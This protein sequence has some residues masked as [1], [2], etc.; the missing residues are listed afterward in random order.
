MKVLIPIFSVILFF[1]ACSDDGFGSED[2]F[3]FGTYAGFCAGDCWTVFLIQDN[4]VFPDNFDPRNDSEL[5]FSSTPLPNEKY[6]I[7][8]EIRSSLPA[9]LKNTDTQIYGCPDCADQG[10]IIVGWT[11]DGV[12]REI[13]IDPFLDDKELQEIIDYAK[14][15]RVAVDQL[16]S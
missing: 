8:E 10:G 6:D 15:V 9:I 7:A 11:I 3:Y 13:R 16:R 5:S 2:V 1:T 12:S 4:E 14:Q